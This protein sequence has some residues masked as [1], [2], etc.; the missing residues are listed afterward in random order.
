MNVLGLDTSTAATAACLL[1]GDGAAFEVLPAVAQLD[2]PPAHARELMPALVRVME[3]GG[4]S[5]SELDAI[6][7]GVG[8]GTFTGL[9]IGVSTA[10]ALAH[11]QRLPLR[12]VSSL[13]ALARGIAAPVALALIDARRGELFAALYEAAVQRWAPFV[14]APGA[15]VD[16]V[17][18]EAIAPLA[19]G[20]GSLR[21]RADLEAG[22]VNVAADGSRCHVVSAL[23]L[24]RLAVEQ[25]D[26]APD[27]VVPDYLREPDAKPT[28]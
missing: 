2:G 1:R 21:F 3:E 9:R 26:A 19:A 23:H 12:A 22:G 4:L 24:C 14:A 7:V 16:R 17:R 25:P 6:A 8:P 5:W 11:A 20:D 15:V 18:L 27:G 13:A 28:R 10:R